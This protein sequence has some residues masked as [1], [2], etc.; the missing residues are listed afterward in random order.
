MRAG[1]QRQMYGNKKVEKSKL[2]GQL[3]LVNKLFLTLKRK[4]FVLFFVLFLFLENCA[5]YCLGQDPE[6][7]P[8]L[9]Q[10]RNNWN[11]NKS[12]PILC[13]FCFWKTVLNIVWIRI[14]NRNQIFT[15]VVITGTA[16]NHYP[17]TLVF[18]SIISQCGSGG[19]N[20]AF[21]LNV[22]LKTQIQYFILTW[23]R[24]L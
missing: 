14:R 19:P 22:D 23:I 16:T 20:P 1:S 3:F 10:S 15:K 17:T 4:D 7:E 11:R 12:L 8:N 9:Y 13:Y 21:Y 5:K 6:S 2:R 18:R 24:R